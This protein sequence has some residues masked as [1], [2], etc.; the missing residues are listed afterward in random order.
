MEEA[1]KQKRQKLLLIG[2][3]CLVFI[4]IIAI[5]VV[6]KAIK[7]NAN[8]ES[9]TPPASR[10]TPSLQ[11]ITPSLLPQDLQRINA[12]DEQFLKV[13]NQVH[14]QYPWYDSFPLQTD[15]YFVYFDRDK[16]IFKGIIYNASSEASIKSEVDQ[17]LKSLNVDISKYSIEWTSE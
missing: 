14:Q 16:N 8:K 4:L 15:Q 17:K 1:E 6:Q 3:G 11:E 13:Q 5:Y 10:I 2:L 12:G 7:P 9:A